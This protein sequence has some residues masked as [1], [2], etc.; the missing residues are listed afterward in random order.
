MHLPPEGCIADPACKTSNGLQTAYSTYA[1]RM[2]SY[3][4]DSTN[5]TIGEHAPT[6]SRM[7]S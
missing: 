6:T 5:S 2:Q 4:T 1:R 3:Y 7:C